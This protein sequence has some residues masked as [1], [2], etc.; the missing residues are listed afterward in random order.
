MHWRTKLVD[1]NY[2]KFCFGIH[3]H[4]PVGNFGWVFEECAEKSYLPFLDV[5]AEYPDIKTTIHTSGPLLE[6]MEQNKPEYIEKLGA[7][8]S[9]GQVEI[10]GGG[11]YE[12]ILT[13]IP[14]EDALAQLRMMKDWAKSRLGANIRGIWLTERIWD[15]SLPKLLSQADIEFT[16]CDTTHFQWAGLESDSIHG[17]YITDKLGYKVAVFPIDRQ[18]RYTIPFHDPV[19]TINVLLKRAHNAPGSIV[20]YADDGEK[21]GVWPGTFNLVFERGWLRWFFDEISKHTDQIRFT[22]FSNALDSTPPSGR[23]MLPTASYL[24][25]T[26]WALPAK[27]GHAL[28]NLTQDLK[29]GN[30]W[31]RFEPFIRGGFWDNFL[32]KYPETNRLQK[33]MLRISEK[34]NAMEDGAQKKKAIRAL[35]RGQCNCAYWHGLFGGLYLNYLRDAVTRNLLEAQNICEQGQCVLSCEIRDFD[36]DGYQEVIIENDHFTLVISPGCGSACS[37]IDL[38]PFCHAVTNVL[39]RRAESYHDA[40]RQLKSQADQDSAGVVSIHDIVKAKEDNLAAHLI[41][42][43]QDRLSFQDHFLPNDY[44]FDDFKIGR[45]LPVND[46]ITTPFDLLLAKAQNNKIIVSC[47]HRGNVPSPAPDT[48]LT[49]TKDFQLKKGANDFFVQYTFTASDK[50][51]SCLWACEFNLT[52]LTADAPDRRL[53]VG[54]EPLPMNVSGAFEDVSGFSCFDGW[55]KLLLTISK[56]TPGCLW[57]FPVETVNQSE[58]GY[59]RTYQGTSLSLVT[60][61]SLNPGQTKTVTVS[62]NIS[63]R[64]NL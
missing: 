35:F 49:L 36:A 5:L 6:W 12:P 28:A 17:Y 9:S 3:N 37:I 15:P 39:T 62:W 30:A 48:S 20:T 23:I 24:E 41:Y 33:R 55:Q 21:F 14:E 43:H 44:S 19:D 46:F 22:H 52:L 2:I 56:T 8:V 60:E 27:A 64:E 31:D 29:S 26:T 10:L 63:S 1:E 11:F 51:V 58:G 25:M 4:Q 45:N 7:L 57:A 32:V 54:T 61:L 42:D 59:E 18:L 47:K 50:A 16:I 53:I 13:M 34:I 40:V 38:K